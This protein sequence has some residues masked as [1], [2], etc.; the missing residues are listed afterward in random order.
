MIDRSKFEYGNVGSDTAG[1]GEQGRVFWGAPERLRRHHVH[2]LSVDGG[3][4]GAR[5][6]RL[7]I[8]EC[9]ANR[10]QIQLCCGI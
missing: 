10:L 2:A 8:A 6:I 7:M 4:R 3:T 5:Q 9:R 1:A